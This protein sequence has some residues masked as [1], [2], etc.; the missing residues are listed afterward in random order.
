MKLFSAILAALAAAVVSANQAD[1]PCTMTLLYTEGDGCTAALSACLASVEL[2][3]MANSTN[4]A[5]VTM[6]NADC[7]KGNVVASD[8]SGVALAKASAPWRAP[9]PSL[10]TTRTCPR[11]SLNSTTATTLIPCSALVA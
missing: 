2:A 4:S 11:R 7:V 5:T 1:G 8:T 6:P 9:S 10:A 3:P